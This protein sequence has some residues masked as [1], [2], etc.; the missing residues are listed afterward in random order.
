MWNN[1]LQTSCCQ[2]I[3]ADLLIAILEVESGFVIELNP[4]AA[5]GMVR[6]TLCCY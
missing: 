5:G 1:A 2:R 3:K 4:A 6:A